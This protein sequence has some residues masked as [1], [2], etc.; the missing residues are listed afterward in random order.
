MELTIYLL[1]G[2]IIGL[3]IWISILSWNYTKI[4]KEVRQWRRK[5]I[6]ELK[7]EQ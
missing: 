4:T 2:I 7:N 6:N 5:F 1:V 3:S